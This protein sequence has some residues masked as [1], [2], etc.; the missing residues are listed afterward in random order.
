MTE[1]TTHDAARAFFAQLI[2]AKHGVAD[3]RL[4]E[5][6]QRIRREDFVGPGPWSFRP[7]DGYFRSE[8]DDPV[9]LYQDILVALSPERKINN[10][11]PSLHALAI[12]N[13]RPALADRVI[14]AGV[15]TGYYT[16]ILAHLVGPT[17]RVDGYEIESDLAERARTNLAGYLNVEVH[18]RSA[19]AES[20]PEA[21]V[22]YVSAGCTHVPTPW[23]DALAVGGR[24][25]L[26]LT[27]ENGPGC[28]IAVT[29]QSRGSYGAAIFS[30]AAFF[31]CVGARDDDQSR[32]LAEALNNRRMEEVHSLRRD[33]HVDDTLWCLGN[34]YWLSTAAPI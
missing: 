32:R 4:K 11:E 7:E 25:V 3:P 21:D 18:S 29:R 15:G 31:P 23:L 6:F 5:A 34:G 28:M 13:A 9:I 27:S 20:L 33:D 1:V 10:G 24:L 26:P 30:T 2:T 17:G 22:I 16:A 19:L 12:A 14:H 8:T